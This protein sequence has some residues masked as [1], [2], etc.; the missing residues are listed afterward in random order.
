MICRQLPQNNYAI[1]VIKYK[2]T[3]EITKYSQRAEGGI[4]SRDNTKA[5]LHTVS[6]CDKILSAQKTGFVM[7]VISAILNVVIMAVV[8]MSDSFSSMYSVY[9]ALSQL[10]WLLPVVITTKLIVR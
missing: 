10:F 5:L 8:I 3:E 4:V 2:N 6:S 1:R 7:G 9:I